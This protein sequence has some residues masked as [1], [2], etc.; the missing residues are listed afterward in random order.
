MTPERTDWLKYYFI[1]AMHVSTTSFVFPSSYSFTSSSLSAYFYSY[2]SSSFTLHPRPRPPP[3]PR[4][5]HHRHRHR[6]RHRRLLLLPPPAP[7]R[8]HFHSLLL[9]PKHFL[10]LS[11][12]IIFIH[13]FTQM[14]KIDLQPPIW[15]SHRKSNRTSLPFPLSADDSKF[16]FHLLSVS[17]FSPSISPAPYQPHTVPLTALSLHAASDCWLRAMSHRRR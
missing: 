11:A 9:F 10:V 2:P 3:P 17:S 13:P 8:P 5:H 1:Q 4:H 7:P 12:I 14:G 6:H 15:S 16:L